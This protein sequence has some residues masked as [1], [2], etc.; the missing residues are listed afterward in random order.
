M[1]VLVT[2]CSI[3]ALSLVAVEAMLS[4][5]PLNDSMKLSSG[6]AS[7][8]GTWKRSLFVAGHKLSLFCAIPWMS[9]STF[10][11]PKES[12]EGL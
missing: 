9:A 10:A 5:S 11:E 12:A 3:T 1:V 7:S 2:R 6:I 8:A 4:M